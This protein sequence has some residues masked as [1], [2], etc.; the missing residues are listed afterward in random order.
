MY[1]PPTAKGKSYAFQLIFSLIGIFMLFSGCQKMDNL[2]LQLPK[3]EEAVTLF[4]RK[5]LPEDVFLSFNWSRLKTIKHA[6]SIISWVVYSKEI[7]NISISTLQIMALRGKPVELIH[8]KIDSA[9][10]IMEGQGKANYDKQFFISR[11]TIHTALDLGKKAGNENNP[12]NRINIRISECQCCPSTLPCVIVYGKKKRAVWVNTTVYGPAGSYPEVVYVPIGDLDAG[13]GGNGEIGGGTPPDS[14]ALETIN[15]QDFSDYAILNSIYLLTTDSYPG[16]EM[17]YPWRW[18]ETVQDQ[19]W[20]NLEAA[21]FNIDNLRLAYNIGTWLTNNKDLSIQSK[22]FLEEKELDNESL[23]AAKTLLE[24]VRQNLLY[25]SIGTPQA[26]ILQAN[27]N[28]FACCLSNPVNPFGYAADM[29][30]RIAYL[31]KQ[32]PTWSIW[33]CFLEA[34]YESIHFGLDILGLI[35]VGGEIFDVLNGVIYTVQGDGVNASLSFAGAVPLAGWGATGAKW[36]LTTIALANGKTLNLLHK[37][38]NGIID[39]GSRSQLREVLQITSPSLQAHHI[40]PWG[41]QSHKIIQDAAKSRSAFHM[42]EFLNGIPID[43]WR[44]QP[45]HNVYNDLIK[46]KL[47]ALPTNLSPNDA[48]DEL[49]KILEK[50]RQAIKDNPTKHLNEITF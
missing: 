31:K 36:A 6:D 34:N 27:Y 16:K 13:G 28:E 22:Q 12:N 33:K 4:A 8:H 26:N 48:Y 9:K 43:S 49:V 5:N 32:H 15:L 42:N 20:E 41:I 18:W 37:S 46:S 17:N 1:Y 23:I 39:F 7:R 47:D 2:D 50:A 3:K 45:N 40:I 19:S 29:A 35:P 44:N 21:F 24:V 25:E 38:I 14:S 30:V 11:Q 10:A